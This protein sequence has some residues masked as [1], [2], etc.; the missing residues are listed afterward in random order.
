[1]RLMQSETEC[2]R[3]ENDWPYAEKQYDLIKEYFEAGVNS[4]MLWN[5]VLDE[6]G[7]SWT[8]W[9]QCSPVVIDTK[10]EKVTYTPQFYA[11][12]HFTYYVQP[13]ATRVLTS[14][15]YR[16]HIAFINPN[17]D[18]VMVLKNGDDDAV[19]VAVNFNGQKVEPVLPPHSFNTLVIHRGS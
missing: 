17:G 19:H 14:G 12:K 9:A 4:Y 15:S 2:G 1:M 13:G 6:T 5:M 10:T 18:V 3:H 8:G 16:E 11:F 7:K